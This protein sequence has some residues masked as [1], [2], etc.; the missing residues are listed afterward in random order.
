MRKLDSG[1]PP[2]INECLLGGASLSIGDIAIIESS[3]VV[4]TNRQS[5]ESHAT[6]QSITT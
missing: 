2:T 4:W 3:E 1:S 5:N 6:T